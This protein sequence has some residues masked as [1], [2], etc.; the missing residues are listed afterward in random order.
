MASSHESRLVSAIF[1][2]IKY[3]MAVYKLVALGQVV[4]TTSGI[5]KGLV[6]VELQKFEV[7]GISPFG[8]TISFV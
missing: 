1:F 4:A 5:L 6:L 2:N 7:N 3:H 8:I